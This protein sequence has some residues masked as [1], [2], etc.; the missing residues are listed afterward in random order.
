M[1][2]A[3]FPFQVI[4]WGQIAPTT[5][6][7]PMLAPGDTRALGCTEA[8]A[9]TPARGFSRAGPIRSSRRATATS[10]FG[11]TSS[12]RHDASCPGTSMPRDTSAA[13]APL[14]AHSAAYT[15][16]RMN[17]NAPGEARS[18]GSNVCTVRSAGPISSASK[19]AA[20]WPVEARRPP[21][22]ASPRD[23]Q[24]EGGDHRLDFGSGN[25]PAVPQPAE[26]ACRQVCQDDER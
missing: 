5:H 9:S 24:N 10:A 1:Q 25:Q 17:V 15:A 2:L 23:H 8:R 3:G 20:N 4:D 18:I 21:G 12:A 7:G 16:D 26:G 14:C 13:E 22:D 6:P 11:T 19:S